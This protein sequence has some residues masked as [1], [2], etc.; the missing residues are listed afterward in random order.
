MLCVKLDEKRYYPKD[1]PNWTKPRERPG[2]IVGGV[3]VI[4]ILCLVG[5]QKYNNRGTPCAIPPSALLDDHALN[6]RSARSSRSDDYRID[7]MDA[8]TPS[9]VPSSSADAPPDYNSTIHDALQALPPTYEEAVKL[10]NQTFE[11]DPAE[12]FILEDD[13]PEPKPSDKLL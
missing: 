6:A 10:R 1:Y 9:P 11:L 4:I 12:C 7:L 8:G 13:T 2:A 3:L 5:K